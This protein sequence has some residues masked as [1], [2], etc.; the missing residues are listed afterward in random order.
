MCKCDP[1]ETGCHHR[2]CPIGKKEWEEHKIL[3]DEAAKA[4]AEQTFDKLKLIRDVIYRVAMEEGQNYICP[5]CSTTL[6]ETHGD[7]ECP[8]CGW[9]LWRNG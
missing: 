1:Y 8:N 6:H 2:D 3:S 9:S 5:R 7:L 4:C